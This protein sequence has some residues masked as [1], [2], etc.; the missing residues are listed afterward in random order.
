MV[1]GE[2]RH[3]TVTFL[4]CELS[5]SEI[6][7]DRIKMSHLYSDCGCSGTNLLYHLLQRG[8]YT[9]KK[10]GYCYTENCL[11]QFCHSN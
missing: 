10:I 7:L 4:W 3:V 9:L 6:A 1:E 8:V 2:I 11:Q 5:S